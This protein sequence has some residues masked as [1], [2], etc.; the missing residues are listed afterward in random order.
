MELISDRFYGFAVYA[1]V[2][3]L[4]MRTVPYFELLKRSLWTNNMVVVTLRDQFDSLYS[5]VLLCNLERNHVTKGIQERRRTM[6]ALAAMQFRP[7]LTMCRA[8]GSLL[9]CDA[10]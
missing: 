4:Y 3:V 9:D 7:W 1:V 8:V 2:C 5:L 6:P 10:I